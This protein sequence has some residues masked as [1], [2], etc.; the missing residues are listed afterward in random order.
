M[1]ADQTTQGGLLP[2]YLVPRT[3]VVL[4][5]LPLTANGTLDRRALPAVGEPAR[6]T[7]P[8]PRLAN[9]LEE[10]FAEAWR[11]VLGTT[12]SVR[13]TASSTPGATRCAT[14]RRSSSPSRCSARLTGNGCRTVSRTRTRSPGC[15]PACRWRCSP[16]PG[17][18]LHHNVTSFR[19]KDSEP[20][21][22][23]ALQGSARTVVRRHEALRTAIRL[24][25]YSA[26]SS[27][28]TARRS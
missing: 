4:P 5:S 3:V 9:P 24:T 6:G 20:L 2:G 8:A 7:G 10:R 18:N 11:Q 25:G 23:A 12:P 15:R 21:S 26:P 28:C 22:D 1:T 14:P 16:N 13:T 17:E 19:G 27:W